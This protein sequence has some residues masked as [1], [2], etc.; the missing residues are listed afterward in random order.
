MFTSTL[1]SN[2]K[3]HI[4]LREEEEFEYIALKSE[5]ILAGHRT[6]GSLGW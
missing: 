2:F 3:W 1:R 4:D 5:H 6:Y